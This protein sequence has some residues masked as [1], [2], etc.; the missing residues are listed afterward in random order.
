MDRNAQEEEEKK[1]NFKRICEETSLHGWKFIYFKNSQPCHAAFWIIVILSVIV[2]S[3]LSI[4]S[5]SILFYY[6]GCS[7]I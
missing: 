6:T 5:Y 2:L 3:V 7:D 1:V 4:L